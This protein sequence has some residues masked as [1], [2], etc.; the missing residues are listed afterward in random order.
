MAR[1]RPYT[2]FPGFEDDDT[3]P[4]VWDAKQGKNAVDVAMIAARLESGQRPVAPNGCPVVLFQLMQACWVRNTKQ[5]PV[6]SDV[7]QLLRTVREKS[8]QYLHDIVVVSTPESTELSYDE[9]LTRLGMTDKKDALAELLEEGKE[10]VELAQ[11]DEDD[12]ND[13]ILE[14]R[15]LALDD[16]GKAQFKTAV[17]ALTDGSG[18]ETEASSSREQDAEGSGADGAAVWAELR[19]VVLGDGDAGGDGD[20]NGSVSALKDEL[21]EKSVAMAALEAEVAELREQLA[22]AAANSGDGGGGS[23]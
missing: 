1:A 15:D 6:A 11:M 10:L 3:A 21:E 7:Q 20:G 16:E 17:L 19:R 2:A 5:R 12:F 23:G 22:A 4:T 18:G 13:D 9:F 8:E 14:D